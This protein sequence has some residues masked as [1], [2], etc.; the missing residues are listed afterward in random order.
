MRESGLRGGQKKPVYMSR[1]ES[2]ST[3]TWP[4]F[5]MKA[6][7]QLIICDIDKVSRNQEC[8]DLIKSKS[9]LKILGARRV[10]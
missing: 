1:V 6:K 4:F 10:T 8:T 3:S 7:Y 9:H 5:I 2:R